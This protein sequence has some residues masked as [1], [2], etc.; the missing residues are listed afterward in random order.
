MKRDN[1][2]WLINRSLHGAI[3]KEHTILRQRNEAKSV[4]VMHPVFMRR[5]VW[6]T[7]VVVVVMNAAGQGVIVAPSSSVMIIVGVLSKRVQRMNRRA[8]Q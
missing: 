3:G 6:R 7:R 2:D 1:Q 5:L 8:R 4:K